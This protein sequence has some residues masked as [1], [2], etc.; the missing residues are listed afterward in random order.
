L[1]LRRLN[2]IFSGGFRGGL[3][4]SFSM[5]IFSVGGGEVFAG[6]SSELSG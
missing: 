6:A 1:F 4:M 5:V 3:A 2:D